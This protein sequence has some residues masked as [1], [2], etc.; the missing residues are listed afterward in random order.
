MSK[1]SR[2]TPTPNSLSP[3]ITTCQISHPGIIYLFI[4]LKEKDRGCTAFLSGAP[5][6]TS[7]QSRFKATIA[8]Q[9]YL[10]YMPLI[11]NENF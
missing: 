1:P 8:L 7:M 6:V 9:A 2:Q 3:S 4:D 10:F 5:S 11:S